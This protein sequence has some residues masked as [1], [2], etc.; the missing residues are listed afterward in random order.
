[1]IYQYIPVEGVPRGHYLIEETKQFADF[2]IPE[3]KEITWHSPNKEE[4]IELCKANN[5]WCPD[6]KNADSWFTHHILFR[7]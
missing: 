1:M 7:E 5:W 2:E 6:A 3:I 4:L